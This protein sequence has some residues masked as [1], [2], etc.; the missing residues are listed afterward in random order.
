MLMNRAAVSKPR[1]RV[2]GSAR[3]ATSKAIAN[4]VSG[5]KFLT[6]STVCVIA[7]FFENRAAAESVEIDLLRDGRSWQ[8]Q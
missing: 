7:K 2:P 8:Q 4:S 3:L 6:P 1:L 5:T